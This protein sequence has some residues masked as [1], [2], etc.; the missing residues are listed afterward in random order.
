MKHRNCLIKSASFFREKVR[1]KSA[2]EEIIANA[3]QV[4]KALC[5]KGNQRIA[6]ARIEKAVENKRLELNKN[7]DEYNAK[8]AELQ[9]NAVIK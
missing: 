3:K 6:A 5:D 1:K 2:A 4:N 9:H 8:E 7:I